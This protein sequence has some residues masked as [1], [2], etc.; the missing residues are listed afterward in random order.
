MFGVDTQLC[1]KFITK[2]WWPILWANTVFYLWTHW[3]SM[4]YGGKPLGDPNNILC[5][6]WD[7]LIVDGQALLQKSVRAFKRHHWEEIG[8]YNCQYKIELVTS[9]CIILCR[10]LL[11][12]WK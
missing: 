3:T 9:M 12:S 6:I 8:F 1:R 10:T 4:V 2:Q 5:K 7:A 11:K